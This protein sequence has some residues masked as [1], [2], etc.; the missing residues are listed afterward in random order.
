M[1]N[2]TYTQRNFLKEMEEINNEKNLI[3]L[4]K[5]FLHRQYNT[6]KLLQ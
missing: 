5:K 2:L 6:Y 4:F 1:R 3:N